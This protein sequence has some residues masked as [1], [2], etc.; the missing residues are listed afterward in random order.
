MHSEWCF[1]G[2][3]TVYMCVCVCLHVYIDTRASLANVSAAAPAGEHQKRCE[4]EQCEGGQGEYLGV[5]VPV[6]YNCGDLTFNRG[7]S[8]FSSAV[9]FAVV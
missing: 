8:V 1:A 3:G 9:S 5:H 7:L 4:A 6:Y 2:L